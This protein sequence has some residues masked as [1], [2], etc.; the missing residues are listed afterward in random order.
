MPD[1]VE[2]SGAR[3]GGTGVCRVAIIGG[4][5]GGL[6]TAYE[7]QR[8]CSVPFE[9]TIYE[10]SGRLG[11]KILTGHFDGSTATYEAG[12]AELY[13]YSHVGED[14]LRELVDELGLTAAPM[15]GTSVVMDDRTLNDL[16]DVGRMYGERTERALEEFDARAKR[17]MSA[18][19]Y[20]DADWKVS[21]ADA[22]A[23]R[24][25]YD[26]LMAVPDE[27]AR[28]FLRVLVHSDLATEPHLTSASYGLQNY[29]MT[30]PD[31]MRLYTIEGGIERLVKELAARVGA[32]V[33]L[34]E[35]VLRV[36]RVEGERL[37]VTSRREGKTVVEEY[38]FVV[39]ALPNGA[40][41][42]IE[43]A[44]GGLE[45]AMHRHHVH[46]EYPAHYLRVNV[47]FRE[48]FWGSCFQESYS[49]LDAFGGCCVYDETAR[50]GCRGVGVL[51][52]LLAGDAAM[53]A[54]NLEDEDLIE[55][56]LESLPTFMARGRE[57]FV[58][59]KVHRWIGSVNGRPG[60]VPVMD[61]ETRH[62]PE[63]DQPNLMVVGDYLFDSTLNGVLDSAEFVA[64][65]LGAAIEARSRVPAAMYSA[66]V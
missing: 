4:G 19:E 8:A 65:M 12:A 3:G 21:N 32:R 53:N 14:P 35:P 27:A 61:M 6:M 62:L 18:Q 5:P 2:F 28:R 43:W 50:N 58:E 39:V 38:D 59:G 25:F 10:A 44:G 16:D 1:E 57:L 46:Y 20:Y 24:T 63:R 29:L 7:L 56:A 49:M 47:L 11:G 31:Y 13:D 55:M 26:E 54:A 60:G 30:D 66:V 23:N 22:M 36:E 9:A 48:M 41:P 37:R 33:R 15:S 34:K 51:G 40:I 42:G 45:E 17:W 52:W 64:E